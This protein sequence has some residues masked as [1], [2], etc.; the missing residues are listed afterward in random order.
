MCSH[1][2]AQP[3]LA[4]SLLPYEVGLAGQ[5]SSS[6]FYGKMI[7]RSDERASVRERSVGWLEGR[8]KGEE[9]EEEGRGVEGREKGQA[10]GAWEWQTRLP[11]TIEA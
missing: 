9:V 11:L 4:E 2:S 7:D 10:A 8:R 5:S 1:S 6:S 3:P